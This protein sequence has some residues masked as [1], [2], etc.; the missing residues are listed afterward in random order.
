MSRLDWLVARPIAHRGLHD[1]SAGIIENTRSAIEAALAGGYAIEVD[2][3]VTADGDAVVHHDDSLDR[4]TQGHGP[5]GALGVSELKRIPFKHTL[6][7]M[8]TLGDLCELVAGRVTLVL[9]LKS[10]FDWDHR[11]AFRVETVLRTYRGLA[12]VMSFDPYPIV[13]IS[14]LAPNLPRGIVAEKQIPRHAARIGRLDYLR[15]VAAARPR[16]VA[17][18]L[19]DLPA[20]APLLARHILGLPLLTW[21]VRNEQERRRALRWA[22]QMI[23]EGFRP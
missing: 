17:Y 9:E 14:K 22:D 21:T 23:F 16:F 1:A 13:V 20:V 8:M 6:D 5:I 10:R 3:Q 4:L 19:N 12:A 7:R 18:A 11:L 2:L 15:N